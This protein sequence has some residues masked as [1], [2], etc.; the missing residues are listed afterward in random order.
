MSVL[1]LLLSFACKGGDGEESRPGDDSRAEDDSPGGSDSSDDSQDSPGGDSDDGVLSF[2]E[3]IWPIH[4]GRCADCHS[5]WGLQAEEALATLKDPMVHDP[6]LVVEGDPEG[7]LYYQALT[8]DTPLANRMPYQV[9]VLTEAQLSALK[10]WIEAGAPKSGLYDAFGEVYRDTGKCMNCHGEWGMVAP[11]N[12]DALYESFISKSAGGYKLIEP[13]DPDKSLVWL[14]VNEGTAPF[15]N[16]M[17][18]S[19]EALSADQVEL[20]RAWIEAGAPL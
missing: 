18:L 12:A 11:G 10:G 19:V 8:E 16:R 20:V 9:E 6:P 15:G 13:G 4:G 17:P 1:I 3:D 7:S 5:Y 2:S 14:K